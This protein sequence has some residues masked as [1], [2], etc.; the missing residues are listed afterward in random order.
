MKDPYEYTLDETE[1]SLTQD[2]GTYVFHHK[3]T[4]ATTVRSRLSEP[5]LSELHS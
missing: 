5:R 3:H 2:Q 4:A 1:G